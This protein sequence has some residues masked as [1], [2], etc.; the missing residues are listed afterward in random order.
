MNKKELYDMIED[1]K[2]CAVNCFR[3]GRGYTF[4]YIKGKFSEEMCMSWAEYLASR[5]VAKSKR[6]KLKARL[7][8]RNTFVTS[9]NKVIFEISHDIIKIYN[10]D[11]KKLLET[12]TQ[13]EA[14]NQG[15][16]NKSFI[17]VDKLKAV[18]EKYKIA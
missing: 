2:I 7:T 11:N 8:K 14:N 6:V 3:R 5:V 15:D 10:A 1:N 13:P 17:T 18:M 9:N 12:V 4:E 16:L